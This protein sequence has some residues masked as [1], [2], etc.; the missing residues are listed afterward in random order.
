MST[1]IRID[2]H[3]FLDDRPISL[4]QW[5]V[6]FLGFLTL[7]VDGFDMVAMGLIVKPL[8][9]GW[10][11]LPEH[12]GSAMMSG[13]FGLVI[14]SLFS[15][16]LADH[17]GRKSVVICSVLFFG[18][19]N[20]ASAFAWDMNSLIVLRFFTGIGLGAAMPNITT[21]IAE[22]APQRYRTTLVTAI[23]C[24]FNVGA[25]LGSS[26][27]G[28]LIEYYGWQSVLI[29]GGI[30]PMI[31]GVFLIIFL[32]ESIRFLSQNPEKNQ[33][34]LVKMINQFIPNLAHVGAQIFSSEEQ[35]SLKGSMTSL[36]TSKYRY[37]TLMIWITLFVAL[38]CVYLLSNW[39]PTLMSDI[40]FS[41]RNAANMTAFY[42]SGG[43]AGNLLTG[44]MMGYFGYHR[45]IIFTI[46]LAA[47]TALVLTFL[48]ASMF[49]MGSFIFLLGYAVNGISPSCYALSASFYPTQIRATGVGWATGIG[50]LGAIVGTGG[51]S[52]ML[53]AKWSV[54]DVFMFIPAVLF[55]GAIAMTIKYIQSNKVNG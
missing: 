20:F 42:Q 15:G 34:L 3:T 10:G 43:V 32:P 19:W 54:H 12:L 48:P 51:G 16:Q 44:M 8:S 5:L 46:L 29:S 18:F 9:V 49:L 7:A 4:R 41:D 33:K 6:F 28:P 14:G 50:R 26:A 30:I 36:F 55:I 2:V 27:S 38:F 31:L 35:V 23:Y 25:A 37:G 53:A 52:L 39:L 40:G 21:L 13:L 17:I 24:G 47:L 22:F 1:A 45:A 11:I